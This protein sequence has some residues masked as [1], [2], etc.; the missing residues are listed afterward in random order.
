LAT[1][2]WTKSLLCKRCFSSGIPL[3]RSV[4]EDFAQFASQKIRFPASR[5]DAQLSNTSTVRTHIR[6]KHHPSGRC[7]FLS[8]PSSVSRSFEL[9]QLANVQTIQ[10]PVWTT[11]SVRS[12][13][14]ISFQTQIW[15]DCCNRPDDVDSLPDE[16]IHKASI[17]IQ[18]QT[19]GRQSACSGRACIRYENCVHQIDRPDAHPPGPD[20]RSLYMEITCSGRTTVRT[21]ESHRQDAAIKQE[22]SSAKFSEFRSHSCP[23]RQPMTTIRTTPSFINPDAPLNC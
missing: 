2:C 17:V 7:G 14:R 9:L 1:F 12:S 11:L 6:L 3:F 10:Q 5:P 4:P 23:S 15:E 20:A 16:I 13:F 21:T 19:F 8:G 22:R 18:I